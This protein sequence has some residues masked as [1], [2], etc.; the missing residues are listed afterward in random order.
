MKDK[1]TLQRI[2]DIHPA[3]LKELRRIYDDVSNSLS[4]T[5][6]C[7]FVQVYRTFEEQDAL[8]AQGRTKPGPKVTD[9]KG[10]QS[11]HNYGLA[12]DFCLINDKNKDGK[13][14][15]DEIIWDRNTDIDK[16][17]VVDW[18][19]VVKIFT[20]SGWKWGASFGDYP[21][22]EKTFGYHWKTLQRMYNDKQFIPGTKY[23]KI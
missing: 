21:H 4:G 3:L 22:F 12:V 19:E 10:G 15:S 11:Y 5:L 23:L 1:I 18:M 8:Y 7:R 20:Q 9:A 17:H 6:G 14:T 16:D 2:E 13:I